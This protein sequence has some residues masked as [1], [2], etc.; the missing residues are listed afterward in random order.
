M[1]VSKRGFQNNKLHQISI[2]QPTRISGEDKTILVLVSFTA[3]IAFILWMDVGV[4]LLFLLTVVHSMLHL[5]TLN[6]WNV[7]KALKNVFY[8]IFSTFFFLLVG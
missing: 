4:G 5:S 1:G 3:S 6:E 2:Q 7:K 8:F